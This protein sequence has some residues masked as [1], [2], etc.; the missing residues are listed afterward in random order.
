[1]LNRE[2]MSRPARGRADGA[3]A[4]LVGPLAVLAVAVLTLRR[5]SSSSCWV[6]ALPAQSFSSR[7]RRFEVAL[8]ARLG[9]D[10]GRDGLEPSLNELNPPPAMELDEV[11]LHLDLGDGNAVASCRTRRPA[12]AVAHLA[13]VEGV[14]R[15]G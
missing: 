11:V 14:A 13:E 9:G 5:R 12:R 7:T 4:D 1:M 15:S 8:E 3:L 2:P 6:I 10:V